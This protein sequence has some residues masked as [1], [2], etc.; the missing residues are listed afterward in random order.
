M[1]TAEGKV[2]KL[3]RQFSNDDAV[4]SNKVRPSNQSESVLYSNLFVIFLKY[5]LCVSL[6]LLV[7]SG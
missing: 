6:E 7:M 4:H 1:K 3:V 5:F 2:R